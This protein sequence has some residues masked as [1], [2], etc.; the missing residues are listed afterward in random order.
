VSARNQKAGQI[1]PD[2]ARAAGDQN[3]HKQYL[4]LSNGLRVISQIKYGMNEGLAGGRSVRSAAQ[5][6]G[7]APQRMRYLPV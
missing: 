1:R 2:E 6:L 5:P 3:T 7:T 4:R